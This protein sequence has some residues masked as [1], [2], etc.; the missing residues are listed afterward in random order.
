MIIMSSI[1]GYTT[2]Y[3]K[4]DVLNKHLKDHKESGA[5]IYGVLDFASEGLN[6]RRSKPLLDSK[7]EDNKFFIFGELTFEI[8]EDIKKSG[9]RWNPESKSWYVLIKD[10]NTI[11]TLIVNINKAELERLFLCLMLLVKKSIEKKEKFWI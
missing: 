3:T 7:I 5:W 1:P 11:E 4:I 10:Q 9:G 8:R 6:R 2:E